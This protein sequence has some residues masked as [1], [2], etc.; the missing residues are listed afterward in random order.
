MKQEKF[1]TFEYKGEI[2]DCDFKTKQE[3]EDFAEALLAE[4]CEEDNI[5]SYVMK[6]LELIEF[7]NDENCERVI[8]QTV[9]SFIEYAYYHG[10]FAEHNTQHDSV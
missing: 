1:W 7:Y 3:A 5:Q 10:D 8:T 2:S 6:D 9:N 4:E